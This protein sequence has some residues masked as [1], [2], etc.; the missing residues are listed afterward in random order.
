MVVIHSS[1]SNITIITITVKFM[2]ITV[3]IQTKTIT[4]TKDMIK[5]MINLDTKFRSRP[6]K[7]LHTSKSQQLHIM[8]HLTR[9]LMTTMAEVMTQELA[10]MVAVAAAVVVAVAVVAAAAGAAV[11]AAVVAVEAVEV[12]AVVVEVIDKNNLA[13]PFNLL[14]ELT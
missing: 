9:W 14:P 1:I 12:V 7:K 4:I 13:T 5:V 3:T 2:T 8:K 10:T 11:V 6:F